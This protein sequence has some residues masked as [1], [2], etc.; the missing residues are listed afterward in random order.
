MLWPVQKWN[1]HKQTRSH[2]HRHTSALSFTNFF[3]LFLPPQL[4]QQWVTVVKA[5]YAS[6]K[7]IPRT[8]AETD[9][10]WSQTQYSGEWLVPATV[11]SA[12]YWPLNSNRRKQKT[13]RKKKKKLLNVARQIKKNCNMFSS[14]SKNNKWITAIKDS[15]WKKKDTIPTIDL[16]FPL[17]FRRCFSTE[18]SSGAA[19]HC[20][21][22]TKLWRW[23]RSCPECWSTASRCVGA[24]SLRQIT[25]RTPISSFLYSFC[26]ILFRVLS[27]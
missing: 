10:T 20:W 11:A 3:F 25:N 19:S 13:M 16:P 7:A 6:D 9:F 21:A 26:F 12:V 8:I 14:V 1:W 17:G 24:S 22:D 2:H 4:Q 15:K 27:L 23:Q 5:C 18:D